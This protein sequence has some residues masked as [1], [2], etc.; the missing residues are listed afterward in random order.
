M[1]THTANGRSPTSRE[2][3]RRST[4]G[5]KCWASLSSRESSS[6]SSAGEGDHVREGGRGGEKERQNGHDIAEYM[7]T[8]SS[9]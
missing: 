7:Y 3:W 9:C 8:I 1:H 5:L 6:P 2:Q 4:S